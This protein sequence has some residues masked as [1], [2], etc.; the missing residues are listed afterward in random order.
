MGLYED[1]VESVRDY[2]SEIV[3][4]VRVSTVWTAVQTHNVGISLTYSTMYDEVEEAGSMKGRPA[5]E[6]LNYLNTFNLTKV[7]IGLATLNSLIPTPSKYETF[8]ILDYI[9][10]IAD[11]KRVVFVGH[12]CGVERIRPKA[13]EL[14]VL[15]RA[16][17]EGDTIDTAAF[18]VIPDADIVAITGSTLAN[19]SLEGLLTLKRK[20]LT[21]LF[22][23]STPPSQVLF[24]YGI[25]VIGASVVKNEQFVLDAISE[26]GKLSNFKKHLE[27][28]V[29]K[30][31]VK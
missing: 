10:S 16:P 23:P 25:D 20:G 8:N 29:L 18:Y 24:D 13:K 5:K 6:L 27:Y 14:I 19:K 21:I 11:N 15:E 30:K 17:R 12:F 4:D 28:I 31:E 2:H 7:S 26:G 1:L 3:K 9:E 22:G